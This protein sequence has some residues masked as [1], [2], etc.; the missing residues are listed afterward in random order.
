[1]LVSRMII[2]PQKSCFEIVG[3]LCASTFSP[4]RVRFLRKSKIGFLNSK[5]SKHGFCVSF[6][7]DRSIQDLLDHAASKEPKRKS[8]SRLDSSVPLT[9]HDDD[10][11]DLELIC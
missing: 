1:M 9:H 5:E 11:K 6:I 2:L 8:T 3:N 7:L 10:S 4:I